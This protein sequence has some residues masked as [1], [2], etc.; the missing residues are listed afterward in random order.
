M[1]D[2]FGVETEN[3]GVMFDIEEAVEE[4]MGRVNW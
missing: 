1:S 4:T 3:N 2:R